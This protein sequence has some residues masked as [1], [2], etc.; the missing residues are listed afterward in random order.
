MINTKYVVIVD[1]TDEVWNFAVKKFQKESEYQFIQTDSSTKSV[2][3]AM[4]NIPD[5]VII[6]GDEL[7]NNE[8]TLMENIRKN[9]SITPI[10][11]VSS[12]AEKE[13]RVALLKRG[14]DFYIKKPLNEDYFYYTIRNISRLISSNRCISG[15]TG[16]PGNVQIA[17]EL[18]RRIMSKKTYAILY[19]DLDN[20]KPYND[21][22]GFMNGDEVIKFTSEVMG[23]AIS[24]KG[25]RGDFLGHIGGDDFVAIVDYENAKKIG[26]YIIKLFDEGIRS[27]YNEEDLEKGW[28][29]IENRKGRLEKYPLVTITVAMI[30]N[31]YKKYKTTLEI[32]EDGAAVKKKAKMI[33]GS[34]FLEDRRRGRT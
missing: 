18:Q 32:G 16:L 8:L 31:K 12:K 7:K 29:R 26:K 9:T 2:K 33:I 10:I 30:S 20:F 14:M 22:Y 4:Q 5:L 27:F 6:N 17:N 24:E 21:K 11:L 25:I 3:E 1:D 28:I 13:H 19:V 34:T 23:K 15:L